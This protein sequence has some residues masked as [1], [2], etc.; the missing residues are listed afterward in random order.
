M[1]FLIA[2][3]HELFLQGLEFILHKEYP[4]TEIVL[5]KNYT[6]IFSVLEAQKDFD[7]ILTDLAM[8][9][10]DWLEAIER[11][12][13]I[14]PDVPIVIISAV[15]EREILQKTYDLGVSGYVSKA[16]PNSLII[17]AINLVLAGGVYIPP[18]ILQMSENSPSE[19]VQKLL[20]NLNQPQVK[21]DKSLTPRQTEVLHCMAEGMSNK[22]I[23]YKLNV[24]EG[25]V[26]IH[27]TLL[28]RTLEVT[29]RTAA[30]RKAVQYGL[31]KDGE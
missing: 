1:K 6:E 18:E 7:L 14:C 13:K 11:I 26:K 2:D 21:S 30:V 28:M 17:G 4:Q 12:H 25:T 19:K 5:A 15:F 27:I 16:F 8:P 9:G 20:K 3:D 23:A 31:L 29:N 10:A 22:Q 24:S